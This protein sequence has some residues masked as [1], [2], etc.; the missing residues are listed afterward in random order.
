MSSPNSNTAGSR[1]FSV[2]GRSTEIKNLKVLKT[3]EEG[4]TKKEYEEYLDK[5]KNHVSINW[6]GGWEMKELITSMKEPSF[7]EPKDLTDDEEKSKLKTA[8]WNM[9]VHNYV[10]Q[11]NLF[12]RNKGALFAFIM[13]NVSKITK[14][15]LKSNV[16]FSKKETE[17]DL[18]WLLEALD[19]IVV[20]FKTVKPRFLSLDDQLERIMT[21]RQSE[22]MNNHDFLNLMK[23][24]V[25]IYEKHGGRF[26]WADKEVE[27]R[28]KEFV[29]LKA[30][31][32]Q[33]VIASEK[34][35]EKERIQTEIK[36]KILAMV[37]IKRSCQKRFKELIVHCKNEFL[38]GN[39]IY[40]TTTADDK[41]FE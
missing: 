9:E 40:P 37:I 22:R 19:D 23:K 15:K 17:G 32:K 39:D 4:G 7:E 31:N 18:I 1:D 12:K 25:D 3:P 11:I 34:E 36:E 29:K 41:T 30:D 10:T 8:M 35:S 28:L 16:C 2:G 20:K 33:K 27:T 13:N 14:G 21:M 24:E 6:E 5:I 38:F 26:L